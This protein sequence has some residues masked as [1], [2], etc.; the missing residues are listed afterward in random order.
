[1]KICRI[2]SLCLLGTMASFFC[3]NTANAETPKPCPAGCFCLN[4]GQA[5]SVQ[6]SLCTKAASDAK[7]LTCDG[8][9]YGI[10]FIIPRRD[11]PNIKDTNNT[12]FADDFS[13]LYVGQFGW[14]G[15]KDGQFLY[16]YH[17]VG[18][19]HAQYVV[20]ALLC[21]ETYPNSEEGSNSLTDCFRY[22]ASGNKIYYGSTN[23]GN[24]NTDAIRST[25][26][27]LQQ[28]LLKAAQDLQT[29]LDKPVPSTARTS[30]TPTTIAPTAAKKDLIAPTAANKDLEAIKTLISV[31]MA[32]SKDTAKTE[33]KAIK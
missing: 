25:V 8:I 6:E 20:E 16:G 22:D 10:K 13:Q 27:N 14:Y 5:K 29:A 24:C 3:L 1:M 31:G 30:K 19:Y 32:D 4:N 21:P 33:K 17:S 9:K 28:A 18:T 26:Q 11:C 12:I 2:S 23:Y 7:T 15:I